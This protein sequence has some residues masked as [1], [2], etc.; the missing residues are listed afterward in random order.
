F[1]ASA[2]LDHCGGNGRKYRIEPR[3]DSQNGK[4]G[5]GTHDAVDRD[6]PG[7]ALCCR[8]EALSLRKEGQSAHEWIERIV[9]LGIVVQRYGE[10]LVGGAEKLSRLLAERFAQQH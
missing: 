1:D 9:K 2:S 10:G 5:R 7:H 3:A 6:H 8:C 4:S